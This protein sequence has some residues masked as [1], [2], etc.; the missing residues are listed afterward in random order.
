[1][2]YRPED[3]K[4]L[5][6]ELTEIMAEIIRVCKLLDIPYFIQGGTAIGAFFNQGFVPWD[7]DID[8]G[9]LRA[10]YQ[11]FLNEAP[12]VISDRFFIQHFSTEPRTPFYFIKVRKN[13]T[14][15]LEEAY[16]DMPI[17]HGIFVDIF[18]YDHVPDSGK[19]ET[20]H[21]RLVQYCEGAF[22]RRQMVKA[23]RESTSRLPRWVAIPL[24][25]LWLIFL[26]IFPRYLFY[27]LL[28]WAQGLYNKTPC[29]YVSIVKMPMDQISLDS[30]TSLVPMKF[31]GITVTAP[32]CIEVYLRHHY[33]HLSPT[34]PKEKQVNHAP[35]SLSFDI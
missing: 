3:L 11:R 35:L 21:R 31:E 7:D 24:S 18:P 17:H 22:K 23:V 25:C 9:M 13:G 29:R 33:P 5:H 10:D 20:W 2:N 1:M 15:F 34:L 16:K 26:H 19:Q 6:S 28:T 14:L 32:S 8:L 4:R 12:R 27:D 30:V